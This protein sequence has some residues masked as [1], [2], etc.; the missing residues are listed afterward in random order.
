MLVNEP[1]GIIDIAHK[2]RIFPSTVLCV[3]NKHPDIK[4]ETK[5]LVWKT[6]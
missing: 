5:V 6:A 1:F 2:L 3:L 4:K